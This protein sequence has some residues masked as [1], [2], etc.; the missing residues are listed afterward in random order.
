MRRPTLGV[1][2]IY[3]YSE[4]LS[5]VSGDSLAPVSSD[6]TDADDVSAGASEA[7]S[8][9]TADS[10]G[11]TLASAEAEGSTLSEAAGASL[12]VS[13]TVADDVSAGDSLACVSVLLHPK[14]AR[15][16]IATTTANTIANF[17]FITIS[18]FINI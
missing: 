17:F 9:S 14:N 15:Q 5:E 8:D 6:E 12:G 11:A 2:M 7:A 1:V 10:A 4:A 18:P 3:F 16:D 13:E